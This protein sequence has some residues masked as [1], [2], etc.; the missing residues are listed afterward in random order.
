MRIFSTLLKYAVVTCLMILISSSVYG[1]S[2]TQKMDILKL[3]EEISKNQNNPAYD[4]NAAKL[5]LQKMTESYNQNSKSEK[6]TVL[7]VEEMNQDN[8][9][10]DSMEEKLNF[11]IEKYSNFK[12][13]L[14]IARQNALIQGEDVTKYDN[15]LKE[16]NSILEELNKK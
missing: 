13:E 11:K 9:K 7:N 12:K 1:Q 14:E 6:T 5:E 2:E 10:S 3:Q 16:V 15:H 4:M 8:S